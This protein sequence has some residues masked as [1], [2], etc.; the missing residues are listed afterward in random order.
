MPVGKD[1]ASRRTIG[2]ALSAAGESVFIRLRSHA[3]S[4]RHPRWREFIS[5]AGQRLDQFIYRLL[6]ARQA[7]H[8]LHHAR[9]DFR[10]SVAQDAARG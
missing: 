3:V 7:W 8:E 6:T 9:L 10:D 2:P 4:G 5:E 1:D